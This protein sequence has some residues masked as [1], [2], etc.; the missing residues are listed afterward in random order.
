MFILE[1][2]K[3]F[4]KQQVKARVSY[5]GK[6]TT[7][8]YLEALYQFDTAP[9]NYL[10]DVHPTTL[11]KKY[12][13]IFNEKN[14]PVSVSYNHW[15]LYKFGYKRCISCLDIL[16][17]SDF[18]TD[19]YTWSTL[20]SMCKDCHCEQSMDYAITFPEKIR[21][22]QKLYRDNNLTKLKEYNKNYRLNHLA[23]DAARSMKRYTRKLKAAPHWLTKKQLEEIKSFY[24]QASK[25]CQETGIEYQ[26]DHI[27]PLQGANVCGLHVPWNLQ[28]ITAEENLRKS[29]KWPS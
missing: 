13:T 10:K 23:E 2:Y 25:K 4:V 15:F 17:L 3:L 18:N 22:S 19:K 8:K 7:D 21:N 1:D 11:T 28:V 29:N 5:Y 26:V 9:K 20:H 16:R 12:K 14:K 27:V 6:D 24:V